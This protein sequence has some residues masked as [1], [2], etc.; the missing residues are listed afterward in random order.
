MG[1]GNELGVVERERDIRCGR[2][3]RELTWTTS[4]G[5]ER[6]RCIRTVVGSG[7]ECCTRV[8][9]R[10]PGC[11]L[12]WT[13]TGERLPLVPCTVTGDRVP[14]PRGTP[15]G[16]LGSE[17]SDRTGEYIATSYLPDR[18]PLGGERG[19][20]CVADGEPWSCSEDG[21]RAV[22]LVVVRMIGTCGG[23]L[24]R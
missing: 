21:D 20:L 7:G 24:C 5:G 11:V 3:E 16:D 22:R 17:I 1:T 10:E 9:D 18:V 4:G 8:G 13:K 14:W 23:L 2:P 15:S 6:E 12:P 19:S